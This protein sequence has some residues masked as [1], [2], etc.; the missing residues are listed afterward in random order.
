MKKMKLR[1]T[2]EKRK[3]KYT[4]F[5]HFVENIKMEKGRD[6]IETRCKQRKREKST[7]SICVK[8]I[9]LSKRFI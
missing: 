3:R 4:E 2:V 1:A 6:A 9:A 8:S 5:V 7:D